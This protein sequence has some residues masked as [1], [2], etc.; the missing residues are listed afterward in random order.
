M[1]WVLFALTAALCAAVVDLIDKYVV[2]NEV[3]DPIYATVVSGFTGAALLIAISFVGDPTL[4]SLPVIIIATLAGAIL[5][6]GVVVYYRALA[7]EEVSRVAPVLC[8]ESLFVVLFALLFFHESFAPMTYVGIIA[9]VLGAALISTHLTSM[10]VSK[11]FIFALVAAMMFAL[12]AIMIKYGTQSTSVWPLLF[13]IGL[14]QAMVSGLLL[15]V[16]HGH[17]MDMSKNGL[18]HL[19][20]G[21]IIAH[22]GFI[23]FTLALAYG[24]VTLVAALI[25]LQP[26]MVFLIV[27]ASS[28]YTPRILKERLDHRTIVQKF[29]AILLVSVGLV[30]IL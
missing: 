13:W 20:S 2:S 16:H 30:M 18:S 10:R 6:A 8:S 26:F 17:I 25:Q 9:I 12:R 11:G 4:L 1:L 23:S 29:S 24:P 28:I 27:T 22:V 3:K 21:A 19:V 5:R 7:E 15:T 14:G